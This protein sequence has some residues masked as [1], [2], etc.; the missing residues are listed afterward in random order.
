[1]RFGFM[2]EYATENDGEHWPTVGGT[3][4]S[5]IQHPNPRST[6]LN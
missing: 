2:I 1:M 3:L 4:F 5:Y 6:F